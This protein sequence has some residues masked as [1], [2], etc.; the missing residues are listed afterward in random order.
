MA[1]LDAFLAGERPDDVA[2]FLSDS[3]VDDLDALDAHGERVDPTDDR[4]HDGGL[5]LVVDGERGRSV[6]KRLTGVDA[7]AFAGSAMD[8]P[9]TVTA[10]LAGGDCPNA[11][12]GPQSH[13]P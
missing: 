5:V 7:M 2:L 12:G 8:S 1:A 10:N 3:F 11:A 13:R 6:F 4:A 9:G